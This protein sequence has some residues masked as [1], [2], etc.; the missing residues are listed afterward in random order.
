MASKHGGGTPLGKATKRSRAGVGAL[1]WRRRL[2]FEPLEDRR[3]LAV[4]PVT[5]TTDE[6]NGTGLVSLREAVGMANTGDT[7]TFAVN[8]T[9]QL[10]GGAGFGQITI[11]KSLTIQG[12][13]ANLLTIRAFDPDPGGTNNSNG[14][15]VFL[16][17]D[18]TF[19]LNVTISSVT[20]TNGDPV[21]I[22][23]NDGGGAIRN[24]EN[25]T[26]NSCVLS[27][28]FSP[29]GGAIYSTTNTLTLNDCTISNNNS[30]DGGAI[31]ITGGN[32][33]VAR[34]TMANNQVTNAGGGISSRSRPVT[35]VDSTV[36]GNTAGESG[37]GIYQLGGSLSV[38]SSTISGNSAGTTVSA[39]GAGGG[40]YNSTGTFSV[41]NSTISGNSA[42]LGGAG[43]FS[44]TSQAV[45]IKF[46]TVT[47]NVA[48]N[49][50]GSTG[51]GINSLNTASLD[52]TIVAGNLRGA[53]TRDDV[54]GNFNA[55]YSLIGDKG[56]A[57]VSDSGGSLIGTTASF[58]DAKLGLLANN[59]GLT[60]TRALLSGSPA[61]DAGDPAAVAGASGVPQ[62]DQRGTP[63]S[64]VVGARV[65]IGAV[66]MA[67][68]T[69]PAL[70]GDY[71]LNHSVDAGDYVLWRKTNGSSVSPSYSG[72]DGDG[73]STV[74]SDDY[75]VWRSHFGNTSPGSGS[76]AQALSDESAGSQS[77]TES[78]GVAD[79]LSLAFAALANAP[80]IRTAPAVL[81]QTDQSVSNDDAAS[82]DLLLVIADAG[83]GGKEEL[84]SS[85]GSSASEPAGQRAIRDGVFELSVD[86]LKSPVVPY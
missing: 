9:I 27:G 49:V 22:D 31:L 80:V 32:L 77:A 20:L 43:I 30:G 75:P 50:A 84:E 36:S 7:I 10:L 3:L 28:N 5:T 1:R 78:S 72:A 67:A 8:G 16:I 62:F 39:Y 25:L 71:N 82:A 76:A 85:I 41:L 65:D 47:G 73:N 58:I 68:A 70:P 17:Q 59:G 52:H 24:S 12:P 38:T 55:Y 60:L 63:F 46:S 81:I 61:L 34:T 13:G 37:G 66:E 54:S 74:N 53:S 45:S 42:S 29:N 57:S 4:I 83:R 86:E 44:N 48:A 26:L 56:A 2:C 51:G 6:N 11:G 79:A 15:R 21:V 18:P 23:E 69:G 14:S 19:A 35:I 40:I 33:A 64:R